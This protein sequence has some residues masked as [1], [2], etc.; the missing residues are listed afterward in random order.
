MSDVVPSGRLYRGFASLVIVAI[1]GVQFVGGFGF[2]R[3]EFWPFLTYPMYAGP[4]Y[5]G[6]RFNEYQLFAETE[7]GERIALEAEDFGYSYWLFRE[8]AQQEVRRGRVPQAL[9]A[10]VCARHGDGIRELVLEDVGY[11]ISR[12]GPVAG[13]PEELRRL[14]VSCAEGGAG[15]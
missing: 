3:A 7:G 12:D 13:A 4:R 5:D 11:S 8:N 1:L 15:Q 10:Q 2:R 14:P 9:V 6:D